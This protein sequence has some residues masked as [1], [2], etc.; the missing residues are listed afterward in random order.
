MRIFIILASLNL[1][2]RIVLIYGTNITQ[3]F[4]F[5]NRNDSYLENIFGEMLN[6]EF[7]ELF[8]RT[9]G[10]GLASSAMRLTS[11]GPG[12]ILKSF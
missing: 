11:L 8:S 2:I 10:R 6:W 3:R 7:S 1:R 4:L 12:D 5:V 9:V